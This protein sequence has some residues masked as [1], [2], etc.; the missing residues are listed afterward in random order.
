MKKIAFDIMGS[1]R[2]PKIAIGGAIRFLKTFN[3]INL[4]L[5]G[6][7]EEIE[8]ILIDYALNKKIRMRIEIFDAKEVILMTDG[9]LDARRK[10]NSS[11]VQAINLVLN[12]KADAIVSGGA[13][14]PFLAANQFNLKL[15]SAISRPGFMPVMPTRILN[16]YVILLDAGAN[17][18]NSSEDLVNFAIMANI[19]AQKILKINNPKIGLLNIGTEVSKGKILQKET[20]KLLSDNNELNFTGNIEPNNLMNGEVDIIICDGFTGN[21]VLKSVEGMAKNL[22]SVIKKQITKNFFRKMGALLVKRGFNEV[23][24]IFD[25]KN[26]GG[27]LLIGVNGIVLKAHGS[28]DERSFFSTLSLA[29]QAI[30][31]DVMGALYEKLGKNDEK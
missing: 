20:Y 1:D 21:I 9:I 6:K 16:K 14:A 5:V 10:E 29:R 22:L 13:T 2:G 27:A 30:L 4:I 8:K 15:I 3:D 28:S 11:M 12:K 23:K 18:E 25:Y 19:Y 24:A 17:I 31:S 7:S 26:T